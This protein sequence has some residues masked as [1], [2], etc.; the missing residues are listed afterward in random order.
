LLGICETLTFFFLQPILNYFNTDKYD[1]KIIFFDKFLNIIN[2]SIFILVALFLF[3]S[4][5]I[6]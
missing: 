5:F 1:F 4:F 2:S 6:I 3:F